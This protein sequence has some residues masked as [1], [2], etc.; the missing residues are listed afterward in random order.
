M[1]LVQLGHERTNEFGQKDEK[2]TGKSK[3]KTSNDHLIPLLAVLHWT[4][5][6]SELL[7]FNC[8]P[9]DWSLG[10]VCTCCC[11]SYVCSLTGL[12]QSDVQGECCL[13]GQTSCKEIQSF[14]CCFW[15]GDAWPI[16]WKHTFP[17]DSNYENR[18]SPC[19]C[20]VG[21]CNFCI[22]GQ[23]RFAACQDIKTLKTGTWLTPWFPCV[24]GS[25]KNCSLIGEC[26]GACYEYCSQTSPVVATSDS[27]ESAEGEK[28][29]ELAVVEAEDAKPLKAEIMARAAA[30]QGKVE[31]MKVARS[32]GNGGK[33]QIGKTRMVDLK[34]CLGLGCC[35]SSCNDKMPGCLGGFCEALFLMFNLSCACCQPMV[36]RGD[37]FTGDISL[38]YEARLGCVCPRTLAACQFSAPCP[39]CCCVDT[40][41]AVPCDGTDMPCILNILGLNCCFKFRP[42]LALTWYA[43]LGQFMQDYEVP[44]TKIIPT[45]DENTDENLRKRIKE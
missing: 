33:D 30:D 15:E 19:L 41:L 12:K 10:T 7:T 32:F 43:P 25:C 22:D 17:V 1:S 21:G 37:T 8:R 27:A 38:C 42:T 18:D 34:P 11:P 23:F 40:R 13:L 5:L 20:N 2:S 44:T 6:S 9:K 45:T 31:A 3:Q 39:C 29:T 36:E 28:G 35:M 16:A 14:V 26:C 24:L 4:N